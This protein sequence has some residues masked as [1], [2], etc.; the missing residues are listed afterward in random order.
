MSHKSIRKL[1]EDTA[2]SLQDDIQYSYGKESDFNQEKKRS[3][4]L[5]NTSPI[6]ST[7]AYRV[8]GVFNYMKQW[9]VEMAFYAIDVESSIGED[10]A[11][12]LDRLDPLVDQFINRLNS[13]SS[14]S[15]SLVIQ[16]INQT[17]FIKAT[18]DIL[19]GFILTF[20][21]IVNDD[22]D[23]CSINDC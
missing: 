8:N 6:T 16:G 2:R 1:I 10:Y 15:D 19:T 13:F 17:P 20:Q 18:A 22:F 7:S 5:I 14:K 23:Y 11:E 12:I 9:N 4:T 21:I 3:T